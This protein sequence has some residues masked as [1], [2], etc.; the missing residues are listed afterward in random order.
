MPRER[1]PF[2]VNPVAFWP[3][4]SRN[5]GIHIRKSLNAGTSERVIDPLARDQVL[6]IFGLDGTVSA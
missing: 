4:H 5:S 1:K 3:L 6:A 2:C